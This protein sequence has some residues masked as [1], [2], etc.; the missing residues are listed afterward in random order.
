[1]TGI[2]S[3]ILTRVRCCTDRMRVSVATHE[4]ENGRISRSYSPR[5]SGPMQQL[6]RRIKI[7]WRSLILI[8]DQVIVTEDGWR[9]RSAVLDIQGQDRL[10]DSWLEKQVTL[11][12][13]CP[14]LVILPCSVAWECHHAQFPG[15]RGHQH[16]YQQTNKRVAFVAKLN[17]ARRHGSWDKL[18]SCVQPPPQHPTSRDSQ[19]GAKSSKCLS[20]PGLQHSILV[21][22]SRDKVCGGHQLFFT[23][24]AFLLRDVE[25]VLGPV[26]KSK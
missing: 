4:G 25:E 14:E 2:S 23:S 8:S 16:S 26:A 1:M 18:D 7:L 15:G 24:T 11:A 13:F 3:K 22:L 20:M 21:S 10:V 19:S 9:C 12:S 5:R 6:Y 17:G